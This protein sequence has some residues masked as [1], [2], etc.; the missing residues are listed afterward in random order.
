MINGKERFQNELYFSLCRTT[1]CRETYTIPGTLQST[2]QR[3]HLT[4][5]SYFFHCEFRSEA[6]SIPRSIV[7]AKY[8]FISLHTEYIPEFLCSFLVAFSILSTNSMLLAF[9]DNEPRVFTA[10]NDSYFMYTTLTQEPWNFQLYGVGS[11]WSGVG[12]CQSGLGG[13][14][15]LKCDDVHEK[16]NFLEYKNQELSGL[17]KNNLKR[18]C[19]LFL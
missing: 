2:N 17:V 19:R 11:R 14:G 10:N 7:K 9:P 6:R 3:M 12:C 5:I 1:N 4:A 16:I 13:Y 15:T 8:S 18:S